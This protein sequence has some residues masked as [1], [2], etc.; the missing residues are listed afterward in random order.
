MK[1]RLYLVL[2]FLLAG[3]LQLDC[4][5]QEKELVVEE[6]EVDEAHTWDFGQVKEGEVLKHSFILENDTKRVLRILD[7]Y[8]S[9]GCTVSKVRKKILAP[10]AK[11]LIETQFD[12]KG[13]SGPIDQFVFVK[14]NRIL[15][16]TVKFKI[17]ADV[18]KKK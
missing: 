17:K 3:F 7:V 11:T 14:T 2:G 4:L 16:S 5:A 18:V 8:T 1:L 9:C 6:L 13:Y 12:S 15:N 10:G